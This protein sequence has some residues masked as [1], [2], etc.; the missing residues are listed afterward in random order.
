MS[1][2]AQIILVVFLTL[3]IFI[4]T[5]YSFTSVFQLQALLLCFVVAVVYGCSLKSKAVPVGTNRLFVFLIIATVLFLVGSTGWFLSPFFFS[6]YF[7][8]MY[9]AFV[10]STPVALAFFFTLVGI[11]SFHIGDVDVTYD[12][13][14][15]LSLLGTVPLTVL[16]RR[17][18]MR[19]KQAEKEI[20]ILEKDKEHYKDKI[21][22]VLANKITNFAVNLRQPINDVKQLAFRLES[23][24]TKA[25]KDTYEKRIITA[26]E[27]A[28]TLLKGFEE[29]VTGKRLLTTPKI[30]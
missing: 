5:R 9:L 25:S 18:Y 20:L 22:E 15:V 1:K 10:F 27:E 13:L 7:L 21:E 6:L 23:Q 16:V 30:A 29:D 24:R 2:T 14:V 17:E 19:L 11:F 28:L 4:F 12:F 26:S 8:G 3:A